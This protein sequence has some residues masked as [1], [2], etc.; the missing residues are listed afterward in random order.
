[1]EA[2]GSL[3][4]SKEP[5]SIPIL[6]QIDPFRAPHPTSLRSILILSSHLRLGGVKD[7]PL[8]MYM[9]ALQRP[10]SMLCVRY[11]KAKVAT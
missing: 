11:C 6:S 8:N 5:A 1:M 7:G 3:P 10:I 2:D 9:T 4:H